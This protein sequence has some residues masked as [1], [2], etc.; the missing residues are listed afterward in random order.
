[1][2]IAVS[3]DLSDIRQL[4]EPIWRGIGVSRNQL[5]QTAVHAKL[6]RLKRRAQ[7]CEM[8]DPRAQLRAIGLL[9]HVLVHS[10]GRAHDAA[11][12]GRI[13]SLPGVVVSE[14]GEV[15][16]EQ[17]RAGIHHRLPSGFHAQPRGVR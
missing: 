7:E 15:Q 4:E 10:L 8:L 17:R 16:L 13:A 11:K 5:I 6:V 3:L 1:M 12:L 14:A 2:K 9:R